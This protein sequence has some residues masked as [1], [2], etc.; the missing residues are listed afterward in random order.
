M[1]RRTKKGGS[2]SVHKV[3]S[4][5]VLVGRQGRV[6][7]PAKMRRALRVAEGDELVASVQ[8]GQLIMRPYEDV[9]EVLWSM[10]RHVRGDL[11]NELIKERRREASRETK[12]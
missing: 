10:F 12:D 11:A 9:D 4:E 2:L 5:R 3:I 8:N 7:I 6:V 1:A